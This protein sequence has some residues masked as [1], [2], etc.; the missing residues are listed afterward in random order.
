MNVKTEQYPHHFVTRFHIEFDVEGFFSLLL[1][2]KEKT[3]T[4]LFSRNL[5]TRMKMKIGEKKPKEKVRLLNPKALRSLCPNT[6]NLNETKRL[7]IDLSKFKLQ[8]RYKKTIN[9]T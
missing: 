6:V 7:T 5:L 2:I 9:D 8:K 3:H 4:S 1:C